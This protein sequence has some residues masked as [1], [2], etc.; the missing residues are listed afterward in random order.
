MPWALSN[1]SLVRASLTAM[2]GNG[3][4]AQLAQG[5]QAAGG[6]L[7]CAD[8]LRAAAPGVAMRRRI[9]RD[10]SSI[11]TCSCWAR[12]LSCSLVLRLGRRPAEDRDAAV[13]Q[14]GGD[15]LRRSPRGGRT[16]S[17]PHPPLRAR[18]PAPRSS[19]PGRGRCR[20][21]SAGQ[22]P[23]SRKAPPER[24]DDGHVRAAPSRCALPRLP[25][26]GSGRIA[27]SAAKPG[28][29]GSTSKQAST[30][31]TGGRADHPRAHVDKAEPQGLGVRPR[32]RTAKTRPAISRLVWRA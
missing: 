32:P 3:R 27:M 18:G 20:P 8:Q 12:N 9:R 30:R 19:A 2:T 28:R 11:R 10:P 29:A 21:A 6:L 1:S 26:D 22:E 25:A 7:R 24:L 17:P 16:G 14:F 23:G 13:P 4:S 31:V 15:R 5:S